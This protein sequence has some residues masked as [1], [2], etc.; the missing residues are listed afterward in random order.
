VR[1]LR[2]KDLK[3]AGIPWSRVHIRRLQER[4]LFPKWVH[5]G[6]NTRALP[7]SEVIDYVARRVAE[8]DQAAAAKAGAAE[9]DTATAERPHD[10]PDDRKIPFALPPAATGTQQP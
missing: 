4:N 6:P 2:F 7:E 1:F 8:R 10:Q 9:R 3:A 5:L